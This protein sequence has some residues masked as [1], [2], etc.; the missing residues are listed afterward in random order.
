MTAK[1]EKIIQA[2]LRLFAQNG[3]ASTSTSK[4]AK[5]AGVSEGL[6]FR[7]F[8]NKEGLLKAIMGMAMDSSKQLLSEVMLA[9]R[10]KEIIR[11]MLELPYQIDRSQYDMWRLT[12]ALKW[13]MNM[14]DNSANDALRLVLKDAFQQLGYDD[15]NAEVELLFMYMDGAATAFLLHEPQ[16]KADVLQCI[17]KKYDL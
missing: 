16:N 14:Y 2:A 8:E 3:Y 15:P 5:E 10:P 17:K 11:K 13:Q 7:H 1:Q 12:Y 4:V 6:I 9:G